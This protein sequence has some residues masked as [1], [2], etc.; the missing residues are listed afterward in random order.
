[1]LGD[2]NKHTPADACQEGIQ[3][4]G[5]DL[6]QLCQLC[7]GTKWTPRCQS[8]Q[9]DVKHL[10]IHTVMNGPFGVWVPSMLRLWKHLNADPS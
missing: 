9:P 4:F 2:T 3:H 10:A 1:M 6:C 5:E 8:L 7:F